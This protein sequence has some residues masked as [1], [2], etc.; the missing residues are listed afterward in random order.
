[1]DSLERAPGVLSVLKDDP[2]GA[3]RE[4][5]ASLEDGALARRSPLGNEVTN[6]AL[7]IK[8]ASGLPL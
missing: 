5:Y 3:S 7:F 4:S 2:R 6:E 8:E 1:M